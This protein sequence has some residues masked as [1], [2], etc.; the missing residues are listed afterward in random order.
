MATKGEKG[1]D[2]YYA[3][4]FGSRWE[5]LRNALRAPVQQVFRINAFADAQST[6]ERWGHVARESLA[7]VSWIRDEQAQAQGDSRG[8]LDGYRMDLASIFPAL[9]LDV[10]PGDRVLDMCAAPGGKTLILAEALQGKGKGELIAN[11]ISDNRRTRLAR[12]IREYIPQDSGVKVQVTGHDAARWCLHEKDAFDRIL[13][14]AP[15]SG[16]RHLLDDASEMRTWSEARSKNLS[17]RQ[18][19]LLAS[20]IQAVKPGGR[21][22]YSTCS[23]STRENDSVIARLLKRRDGEARV[24]SGRGA[25]TSLPHY[26]P[27]IGEPTDYGWMILPDTTGYGPIYFAILE[28]I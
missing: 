11:E 17:V 25:P 13:L 22:V 28:K 3:D 27:P 24:L 5:S 12:V 16:E 20:A 23:L 21:I 18:Y 9:A 2:T 6:R 4:L 7:G 14:D 15:C 8:L 1:F 26:P 10:K 19:T